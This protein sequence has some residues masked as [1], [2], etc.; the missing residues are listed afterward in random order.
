[1]FLYF[2]FL[3]N[4][5]LHLINNFL[6]H[7]KGTHLHLIGIQF[8]LHLMPPFIIKG[9]I[10]GASYAIII[11]LIVITKAYAEDYFEFML[12]QISTTYNL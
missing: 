5:Y 9:I 4:I 12:T 3:I 11:T 7:L 2:S 6:L 8:P 10:A 1:M